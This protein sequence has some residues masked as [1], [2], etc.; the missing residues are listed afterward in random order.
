MK[1]TFQIL[2]TLFLFWAFAQ[3]ASAQ[4]GNLSKAE[5]L[6]P[7]GADAS[8]YCPR[9][10]TCKGALSQ[11]KLYYFGANNAKVEVFSNFNL[12]TQIASFNPVNSGQLLTISAA[13]LPGGI[14]G[15]YIYLRTTKP[16]ESACVTKIYSSCPTE[17]WPGA[18]DDLNVLGKTFDDFTVYART[19]FES[20]TECTLNNFEQ[21]W[22]V[23]GN[24]IGTGKNTLGTRT[25]QDM[26]IITNDLP[27]GVVS[28]SGNFGLGTS[29][30]TAR[31]EVA[32]NSL[33]N[34]TLDVSDI[35]KIN[36]SAGS[37]SITNG[38]LQV[39][40]GVGIAQNLNTGGNFDVDG[41]AT[42]GKDLTVEAPGV[43]FLKSSA[44]ST[45]SANG[46]LVVTGGAGIGENLNAGGKLNVAGDAKIGGNASV[47]GNASITG[48]ATID[49][50]TR[51]NDNACITGDLTVN[52]G[53]SLGAGADAHIDQGSSLVIN[54]STGPVRIKASGTEMLIINDVQVEAKKRFIV[55]GADLAERFTVSP[56]ND[57]NN[58]SV[59]P[60]MV[61]SIDRAHPGALRLSNTAYDKTVAGIVSGAGGIQTAIELG[62]AGSIAD[63][64]VSVAVIG[65]VY[66]YADATYG[67]IEPGDLLS[68][69]NTPGHA[70]KVTNFDSAHGAILGKAMSGLK[71]GKGL[72]LVL[73]SM[74]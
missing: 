36:S 63:G 28:K 37:T 74:Q 55:T 57:L 58:E 29:A 39:K 27:R 70:M 50:F 72:I 4:N 17:G 7:A 49:G 33:L 30:P 44:S 20:N 14:F 53:L 46:A 6:V 15:G 25:N 38:A 60:G 31:L 45:S 1:H 21:D 43:T 62:Q 69:S 26:V 40:G 42:V 51:I 2:T 61:V 66:C 32:G 35:T 8:F 18:L 67:S 64:Q 65:R 68:T 59:K 16:G 52:G 11:M 34:G 10:C 22:H 19:D 47:T 3:I 48:D 71:D 13:G 23:G 56:S 5:A 54:N 9:P 24:I 73:I 12:L 41:T